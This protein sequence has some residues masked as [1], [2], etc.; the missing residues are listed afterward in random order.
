[1]AAVASNHKSEG[2]RG[3]NSDH[4][5]ES[6]PSFTAVNGSA[7][8][9]QLG[10]KDRPDETNGLPTPPTNHHPRAKSPGSASFRLSQASNQQE[11]IPT[12]HNPSVDYQNTAPSSILA[13]GSMGV[14]PSK[15]A[16]AQRHET[17]EDPNANYVSSHSRTA[18]SQQPKNLN[19]SPQKRKRTY[20]GD[21]ENTN[22]NL[23]YHSHPLP[24]SPQ[25]HRMYVPETGLT[26]KQGT[27]SPPS[28]YPPPPDHSRPQPPELYPRPERLHMTRDDYEQRVDPNIAPAPP[29]PYYS[30]DARMAEALQRENRNYDNVGPRETFASPEEEDE[31]HAQQY[32]EYGANRS[33]QSLDMDRKRRKRV[34]SNRTKT[35]CMTCRRRKKKCDEQHPECMYI[36]SSPRAA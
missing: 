24:N 3:S 19:T 35:G 28:S 10:H 5:S 20:S 9:S 14:P 22:N 36:Q 7:S 26:H 18:S 8:A 33:S 27:V 29:R 25:K 16:T 12:P 2:F 21:Y 1:M 32:G 13:P 23:A 15:H 11:R 34:F 4:F 31:L 17:G 30:A 6:G